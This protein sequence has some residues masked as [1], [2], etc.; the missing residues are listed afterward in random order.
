MDAPV[1]TLAM[2]EV[3]ED[4]CK[5]ALALV[6]TAEQEVEK[7]QKVAATPSI[8]LEKVANYTVPDDAIALVVEALDS[9]GLVGAG[10]RD[11]LA[12]ALADPRELAETVLE[13][14]QLVRPSSEAGIPA[15]FQSLPTKAAS[16]QTSASTSAEE[17]EAAGWRELARNG[18]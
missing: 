12:L 10:C 7:A 1:S 13:L 14:A 6:D 2:I 18:L 8:I 11:K 3:C 16:L 15:S 4:I 5:M 9:R 17:E